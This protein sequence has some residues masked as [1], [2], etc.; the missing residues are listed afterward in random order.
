[1][2]KF[3]DAHLHKGA[4]LANDDPGAKQAKKVLK[5][6]GRIGSMGQDGKKWKLSY[7]GKQTATTAPEEEQAAFSFRFPEPG[8][9]PRGDAIQLRDLCFAYPGC[10]NNLFEKLSLPIVSDSRI[11]LVGPNGRMWQMLLA[12]S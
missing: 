12:T 9:L 2:W 5:D 4:S 10:H 3:V 11:C 7:D 1:M 8:P 6:M